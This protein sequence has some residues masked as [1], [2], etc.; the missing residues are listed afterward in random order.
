[1]KMH[2]AVTVSALATHLLVIERANFLEKVSHTL[3]RGASEGLALKKGQNILP[4][5]LIHYSACS[6]TFEPGLL[7]SDNS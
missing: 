2:L 3:A 6:N 7:H 4:W 1:M 5:S